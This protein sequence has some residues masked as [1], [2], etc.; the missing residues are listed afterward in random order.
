M[1][2]TDRPD[3]NITWCMRFVCWMTR[4][5]DTHSEYFILISFP[6]AI[7]VTRRRISVT[8]YVHYLSYF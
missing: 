2:Q 3:D 7:M 6:T 5:A 1:V 4:T 8:S